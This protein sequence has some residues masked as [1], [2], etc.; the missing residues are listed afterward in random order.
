MIALAVITWF[1]EVKA[2]SAKNL[3]ESCRHFMH[4][5]ALTWAALSLNGTLLSGAARSRRRNVVRLALHLA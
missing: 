2:G 3:Q 4:S 1:C 5:R